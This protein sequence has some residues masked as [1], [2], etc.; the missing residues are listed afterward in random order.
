M[1]HEL[2]Y[3]LTHTDCKLSDFIVP[4]NKQLPE[5]YKDVPT[6]AEANEDDGFKNVK[7]CVSFLYLWQQSYLMLAPCD[8]EFDISS[9]GYECYVTEPDL[10]RAISHTHEESAPRNQ[11]G[12][13]FNPDWMNIKIEMPVQVMGNEHRFDL[14][15][16]QPFYWDQQTEL[17]VAPGVLPIVP[18]RSTGFNINLFVNKTRNRTI[19]ISKGYPLA[20]VYSASGPIKFIYEPDQNYF[21]KTANFASRVIPAKEYYKASKK[22]PYHIPHTDDIREHNIQGSNKK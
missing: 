19:K 12:S 3:H 5:W 18:D 21:L 13:S 16:T 2:L 7:T 15:W 6:F 11:M 14:I 17:I 9:T 1:A 4:A 22:C 8:M 20:C 10:A